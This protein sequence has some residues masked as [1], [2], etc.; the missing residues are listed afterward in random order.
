MNAPEHFG[1]G[2]HGG[3]SAEELYDMTEMWNCLNHITQTIIGRTVE[4]R[5]Y[6]VYD[7][8]EVRGGDIDGEETMLGMCIPPSVLPNVF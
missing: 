7:C 2:N 5:Q 4:A 1:Q 3:L 6:G 8:T